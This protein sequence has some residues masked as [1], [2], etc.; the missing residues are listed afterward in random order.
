M[1]AVQSAM[2]RV[3]ERRMYANIYGYKTGIH[4][5]Q[6]EHTKE[7]KH[8]DAKHYPHDATPKMSELF[9]AVHAVLKA[10]YPKGYS[11]TTFRKL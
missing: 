11:F 1:K 3:A 5:F 6:L 8:M 9:G 10:A 7:L 4:E 2:N